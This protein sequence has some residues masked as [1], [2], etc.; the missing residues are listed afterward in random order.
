MAK[1]LEFAECSGVEREVLLAD[2]GLTPVAVADLDARVPL[3]AVYSVIESAVTRTGDSNWGLHRR[4]A[5]TTIHAVSRHPDGHRGDRLAARLLG[6]ERIPSSLQAM[7]RYHPRRVPQPPRTPDEGA[8]RSCS[9]HPGSNSWTGMR[10]PHRQRMTIPPSSTSGRPGGVQPAG[11]HASDR[12]A[13][14]QSP[15][16]SF[17]ANRPRTGWYPG[18][19]P[20]DT[21][22][23]MIRYLART[24]RGLCDG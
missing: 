12:A 15:S 8:L 17:C 19:N 10:S 9:A 4:G 18:S 16:E 3:T 23:T 14:R 22:V 7:D 24:E 5:T 21:T 2:A 13:V 6:G 11:H 20:L 1:F